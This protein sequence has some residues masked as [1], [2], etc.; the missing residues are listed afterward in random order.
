[1]I[2]ITQLLVLTLLTSCQ[3]KTV[4]GHPM[5]GTSVA[6][7]N[8]AGAKGSKCARSEPW[9]RDFKTDPAIFRRDKV[10]GNLYV[11]GDI[12]GMRDPL[13]ALL[14]KAAIAGG[15]ADAPLW[16]GGTSTLVFVGDLID[17]GPDSLGVI[18]F[19]QGLQDNARRH[20]GTVIAVAGNHEMAFLLDPEND[21]AKDFS[22]EAKRK[23]MDLCSDVHEASTAVGSWLRR[24]PAAALIG[25]VFISHSGTP[26][27][28]LREIDEQFQKF[29]ADPSRSK[30]A[31]GDAKGDIQR[32]G[33]FTGRLWWGTKD[34]DLRRE[35]AK[36]EAHQIV[37]GHDPSAFDTKGSVTGYFG[38]EENR[39]IIRVDTGLVTGGEGAIL[40]C[41]AWRAQGGCAEFSLFR[42]G[43]A[44]QGEAGFRPFNIEKKNPPKQKIEDPEIE[45]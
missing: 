36:V 6:S 38:D 32:Q 34:W 18:K 22:K 14:Q 10:G 16:L 1:M 8:Q 24:L 15:T 5:D 41:S 43:N 12:H 39:G 2:K 17:K 31:C 37:F 11:V 28:S 9:N 4:D 40:R 35:L 20:G 19:V 21:K 13:V 25:G 27:Y 42:A 30:W 45:C 7:N 44:S 29:A 3:M 26:E 33:F 23:G